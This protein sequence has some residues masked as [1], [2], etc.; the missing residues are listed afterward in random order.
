MAFDAD[1]LLKSHGN[2]Q[3]ELV[4][5]Y[6]LD[7]EEKKGHLELDVYFFIPRQL[8][9]N[10]K[11]WSVDKFYRFLS[12][13]TR[14]KTPAVPLKQLVKKNCHNSPLFRIRKIFKKNG[15]YHHVDY[16]ILITELR[17]LLNII[18]HHN[19][20]LKKQMITEKIEH[21]Q[22][23]PDD[24]KQVQ[25]A[26]DELGGEFLHPDSAAGLKESYDLCREGISLQIEKAAGRVYEALSNRKEQKDDSSPGKALKTG[27][28]S[29]IQHIRE[30]QDYRCFHSYCSEDGEVLGRNTEETLYREHEIKKWGHQS[31][32]LTSESSTLISKMVQLLFGLAAAIA[33]SIAVMASLLSL[34]FF[35]S[36]SLAWALIAVSAYIL[37]DRI[38]DGLRAFFLRFI[39]D[40]YADRLKRLINPSTGK[41]GG[42]F[43][44]RL[45]FPDL[46]ELP[47]EVSRSRVPASQAENILHYRKKTEIRSLVL[48]EKQEDIAALSDILRLDISSW[49]IRMDKAVETVYSLE[50]DTLRPADVSRTYRI[51][52]LVSLNL[53]GE[54]LPLIRSFLIILDSRGIRRIEESNIS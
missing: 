6:P 30:Q 11:S 51:P 28:K 7:P 46:S 49:F 38:K 2:H 20:C 4:V 27:M 50:E 36:G 53:K 33:M 25:A 22:S 16:E 32:Y 24:M 31:L 45:R 10:R 40:I 17:S 15:N 42:L 5:N 35:E 19:S 1:F 34:R 54:A 41:R 14:Y 52:A 39:P 21:L 44:E 43:K 9:V 29:C 48:R 8:G 18:E 3:L 47:L 26:L 23:I 37:K 12:I 13:Y